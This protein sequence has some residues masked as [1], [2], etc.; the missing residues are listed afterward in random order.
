MLHEP[1]LPTR[2]TAPLRRAREA[3][4]LSRHGFDTVLRLAWT[5]A[6]LDGTDQP[7]R[8]HIEQALALRQATRPPQP[9]SPPTVHTGLTGQH[10]THQKGDLR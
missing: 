1:T 2:V 3:G 7:E 5:A 4:A 8:H 10:P 6:D 9:N